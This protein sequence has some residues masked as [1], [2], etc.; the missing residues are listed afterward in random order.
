VLI[1]CIYTDTHAPPPPSPPSPT[2]R[3]HPISDLGAEDDD[4]TKKAKPKPP[5]KKKKKKK[6]GKGGDDGGEDEG[7]EDLFF[8]GKEI[9]PSF[10][11]RQQRGKW[12]MDPIRLIPKAG[13]ITL[14]YCSIDDEGGTIRKP[15][16]KLRCEMLSKAGLCGLDRDQLAFEKSHEAEQSKQ[17]VAA[18]EHCAAVPWL[19][20]FDGRYSL[21]DPAEGEH[22]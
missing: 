1:A 12:Q 10:Q 7:G 14:A 22:K 21:K 8:A 18:L 19:A 6:K 16:R 3:Y 5:P 9:L 11:V 20:P 13:L 17:Y 4:G 15:N 2:Y